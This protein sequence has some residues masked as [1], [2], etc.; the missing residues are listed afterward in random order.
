M[1]RLQGPRLYVG[2]PWEQ[3]TAREALN[4]FLQVLRGTVT[5]V[6]QSM[7]IKAQTLNGI[8]GLQGTSYSIMLG[9]DLG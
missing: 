5:Y 9:E 7:E 8:G 3:H 4:G 6:G 2:M 1:T